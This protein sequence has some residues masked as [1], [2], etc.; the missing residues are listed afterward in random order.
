MGL[1]FG[2]APKRYAFYIDVGGLSKEEAEK[3]V[4]EA[5]LKNRMFSGD[6]IH[7]KP[8]EEVFGVTAPPPDAK[9]SPSKRWTCHDCGAVNDDTNRA[10]SLSRCSS[11]ATLREK[12]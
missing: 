7:C 11:C 6:I 4:R 8:G 1:Y 2:P 10:Q 5:G 3:V 12:R 9:P